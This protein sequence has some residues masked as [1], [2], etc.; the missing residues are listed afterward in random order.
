MLAIILAMHFFVRTAYG[1]S[2]TYFATTSNLLILGV[3]QGSGAAPCIWMCVSNVL[4]QALATLTDGFQAHCPA[5]F[6]TLA[7]LAK[8]L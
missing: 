3:L 8:L 5:F 7:D 1:V 6:F 4:F 2:P